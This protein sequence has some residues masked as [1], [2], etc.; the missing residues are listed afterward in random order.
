MPQSG[1]FKYLVS[2]Q[3]SI[4]YFFDGSI[5]SEQV[6]YCMNIS[7]TTTQIVTVDEL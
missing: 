5:A 3:V 7:T 1:F 2:D 4:Q 6:E